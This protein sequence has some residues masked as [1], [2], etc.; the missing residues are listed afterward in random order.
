MSGSVVV[1]NCS[2]YESPDDPVLTVVRAYVDSYLDLSDGL[3][4]QLALEESISPVA[5]AVD[6]RAI[7]VLVGP[8]AGV[9]RLRVELE[10]VVDEGEVVP[11]IAMSRVQVSAGYQVL[12][13][14][15][16][17]VGFEVCQSQVVVSL[18]LLVVLIHRLLEGGDGLSKVLHLV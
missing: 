11:G 2:H 6:S 7:E 1:A 5:E 10:H 17:V 15:V 8:F 12:L 4:W 14:L 13:S 9:N 3:G 18:R 16:V